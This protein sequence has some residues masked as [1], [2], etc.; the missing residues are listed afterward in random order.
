MNTALRNATIVANA[1]SLPSLMT[2]ELEARLGLDMAQ[3]ARMEGI[4]PAVPTARTP[5]GIKIREINA[6][7]AEVANRRVL[8]AL[9]G[10]MTA[11]QIA[12]R[13]GVVTS[14]AQDRLL[15]L[16][17]LGRVRRSRQPGMRAHLWEAVQ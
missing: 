14:S 5:P 4:K 7:R 13:I 15:I 16:E 12:E 6:S 10:R 3:R 17:G 9:E 1:Y 11:G 2:P 8:D